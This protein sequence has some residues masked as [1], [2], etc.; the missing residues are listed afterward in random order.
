MQSHSGPSM[1]LKAQAQTSGSACTGLSTAA[2]LPAQACQLS[3]EPA[4]QTELCSHAFRGSMHCS[5]CAIDDQ[6]SCSPSS[7]PLH[8]PISLRI[9]T[10]L[11]LVPCPQPKYLP[12]YMLSQPAFSS[13]YSFFFHS[14]SDSA[15][16]PTLT[17]QISQHISARLSL[18]C[19][20]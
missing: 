15:I 4:T 13:A 3:Q 6:A 14:G 10:L 12:Q 5:Y 17:D 20:I 1:S 8:C 9:Y 18:F 11:T 19:T 7:F 16:P 2:W